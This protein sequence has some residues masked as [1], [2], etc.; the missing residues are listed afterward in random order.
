MDGIARAYINGA[1]YEDMKILMV[2]W[3]MFLEKILMSFIV[4]PVDAMQP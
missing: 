4:L 2:M 1:G 3:K